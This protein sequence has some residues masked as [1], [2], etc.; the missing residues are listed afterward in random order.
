L[1]DDADRIYAEVADLLGVE[2]GARIDVDLSGSATNTAGTA[3]HER[4]RMH[5]GLEALAT[6]A[7]E[8]AH[9]L[10]NRLAGGEQERELAK[11]RV[12]NEGLAEWIENRVTTGSGLTDLNRLQAAIV[13][14]RQLIRAE[15]LTDFEMLEREADLTLQYPLGAALV[16]SMVTRYGREAP[17][18]LLR[19]LGDPDFPRDLQKAELW[20]AAF[21]GSGFDLGL[22]FADYSRRLKSWE[23]EFAGQINALPRPRGSLVRDGNMIGVELRLDTVLPE[24]WSALMRAR[25]RQ[26][27]PLTDYWTSFADEDLVAWIPAYQAI[28]GQLCFQPGVRSFG[29]AIFESWVCLSLD[30]AAEWQEPPLR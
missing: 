14:R 11:M 4:I 25:P 28:D 7:H 13:S 8:T 24:G 1:L 20:F 18:R 6:L 15:H 21:Q 3:F 27:S 9:V 16:D 23:L 17:A 10:A 30:S 29:A 26:D 2:P 5:N 12:F 19:T 22:V